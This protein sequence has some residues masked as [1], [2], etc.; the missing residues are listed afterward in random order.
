MAAKDRLS[1]TAFAQEQHT[2][3]L[4]GMSNVVGVGT[5]YKVRAGKQMRDLCVQ[6]FVRRKVPQSAL[7]ADDLVSATVE[8][9]EGEAVRTDVVEIGI[10]EAFEDAT[11]YRPVPGGCSIGSEMNVSAGTLGGWACDQSDDS[12]VLLTNNHVISNL[13][14][15]PTLRRVVQPGRFDG[16]TLPADVIGTLKRD[17]TVSTVANTP[18]AVSPVSVV[19]A[20]IA[21]I[22]VDRTDNVLDVAPAIYDVQAPALGM[23]VQKR[24]RTTHLTSNGRITSVNVT[25]NVTYMSRTRLGQIANSFIISSTDGHP[26]SAAGDSGS[27]IF[28][29]QVGEVDGTLP[30]VGLLFGGGEASDGTPIT[31]ANDINAVFGALNLTTVCACAA[32]AVLAAGLGTSRAAEG[33]AADLENLASKERQLRR[34]RSQLAGST[35]FGKRLDGFITKAAAEVGQVLTEDEEG[36]GLAVRLVEPWLAHR[37]NLDLLDAT[38][39]QET[40]KRFSALAEHVAKRRSAIRTQVR[41]LEAIVARFEGETLRRM[42]EGARFTE[43]AAR[44]RRRPLGK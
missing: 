32:R 24:G 3:R 20:A 36:F 22:S 30:V 4:L 19:D 1:R 37:T 13:D 41:M 39:D 15:Q 43:G 2:S 10:P 31:I 33:R 27:L 16:G 5:G 35:A 18:T 17:V 28:S 9:R 11:R 42:F 38:L 21:T 25:I 26:F 29:Q 23:L 44:R 12:I 34:L 7:K 14:T 6:V 8:G 40:V